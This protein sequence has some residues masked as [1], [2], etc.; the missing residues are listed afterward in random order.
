VLPASAAENAPVA[1]PTVTADRVCGSW[2]Q[3]IPNVWAIICLDRSGALFQ[4]YAEMQNLSSTGVTMDVF[5]YLNNTLHNQCGTWPSLAAPGYKLRCSNNTWRTAGSPRTATGNFWANGVQ[6]T[7][8][9][10][11]FP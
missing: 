7:L 5:V 10:P 1:P 9:T 6:K 8:V 4:P 3:V 2:S 11:S